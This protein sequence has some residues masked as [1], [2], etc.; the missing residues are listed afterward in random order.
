MHYRE[1]VAEINARAALSHQ[2]VCQSDLTQLVLDGAAQLPV[3]PDSLSPS[4]L[5]SSYL[6]ACGL[7]FVVSFL[8]LRSPFKNQRSVKASDFETTPGCS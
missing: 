4:S 5:Y 7:S 8:T 3:E 1:A 6:F 2:A